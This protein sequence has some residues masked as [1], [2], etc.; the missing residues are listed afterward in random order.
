MHAMSVK[1]DA[2]MKDNWWGMMAIIMLGSLIGFGAYA[3][4]TGH[5]LNA[6]ELVVGT[7]VSN[8]GL[9]LNY[10]YGSSKGSKDKDEVI[11]KKP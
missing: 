4:Y 5:S 3:L 11:N 1:N 7:L 10:R 8:L 6:A 9:L 2:K